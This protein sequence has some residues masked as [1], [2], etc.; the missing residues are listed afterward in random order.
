MAEALVNHF[1]GDKWVAFSAGVEPSRVN[2]LTLQ[3]LAEIG[4]DIAG[5]YSKSVKEFVDRDDLDLIITVCDKA[6]QIC[7]VF[8]STAKQVYVGIEDPALF[9]VQPDEV[10]LPKFRQIRDEIRNR[11]ITALESN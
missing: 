9:T 11:I 4:I 5:Y 1:L 10:A 8:N 6:R 2:P 3:V 7:P